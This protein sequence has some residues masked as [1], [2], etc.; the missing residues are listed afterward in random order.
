MDFKFSK[1]SDNSQQQDA[2]GEK[3]NQSALVV[4]LL[5]LVGGFAYLYFFTGLI[6]P[7]EEKKTAEA[8]AVSETPVKTP[9]PP[10]DA[11]AIKTEDKAVA[12]TSAA[13][14]V[15]PPPKT[16]AAPAAKPAAAP[17]KPPAPATKTA[18]APA[19]TKPKEE[20]KKVA[21]AK[22]VDK[23]PQPAAPV[24]KK[25]DK[26]A[27]AEVNKATPEA[28][29][30][31][32]ADKKALPAKEALKKPATSVQEKPEA[33]ARVHKAESDSWLVVVGSYVLEEALS[34]DMGR[35]RKAGLDPV[36]KPAA[37]KKTSM[38]RLFVSD[39]NDRATAQAKLEKLKTHTSDAFVIEQGGKFSLFAGSYLQTE[40]AKSEQE[41]LKA[42]GFSVAVKHS[43]ISI[44]AQSLSVGP[45]K[46]K[47]AAEAALAKLKNSGLKASLSQ[48]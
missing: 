5:I 45:F 39:F 4:L 10:R 33:V 35:V 32:A 37:R 13:K 46:N 36:V 27:S 19:P 11:A 30:P 31:A 43:E 6:K 3:K 28:K 48:K 16:A 17:A 7:L 15:T 9:L 47:K 14:A 24:D 12:A 40:S 2:P 20:P 42:A 29:K 25:V 26:I 1:D 18:P 8:P 21:S 38:N 23:K 22:P 41:R 44:P 34:A